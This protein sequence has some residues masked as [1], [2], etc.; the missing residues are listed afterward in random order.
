MAAKFNFAKITRTKVILDY[1]IDLATG[2]ILIFT[3][4]EG[5]SINNI[6]RMDETFNVF[7]LVISQS[8]H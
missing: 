6:R 2:L 7:F 4:E 8:N 3:L 1:V 5:I